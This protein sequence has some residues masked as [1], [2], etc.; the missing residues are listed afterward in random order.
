MKKSYRKLSCFVLGH[1]LVVS[2]RCSTQSPHLAVW[3]HELG[4]Q[5]ETG[6]V[7]D[8]KI[9]RIYGASDGIEEHALRTKNSAWMCWP[10][11]TC[12]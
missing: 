9:T 6:A 8:L 7:Q 5:I 12:W 4:I 11:C 1:I 2:L 10:S 3:S